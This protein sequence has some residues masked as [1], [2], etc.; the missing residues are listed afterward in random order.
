MTCPND[1]GRRS[2]LKIATAFGGG[3]TLGAL[4]NLAHAQAPYAPVDVW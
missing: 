2:F 1:L 4:P 3:S